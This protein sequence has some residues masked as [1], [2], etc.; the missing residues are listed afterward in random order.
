MFN[1]RIE[2]LQLY[3]VL[4]DA[5]NQSKRTVDKE[6]YDD[7]LWNALGS[8]LQTSTAGTRELVL[9]VDDI[10]ESSYREKALLYRL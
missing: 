1:K 4:A 6:S 7:L 3:Q 9:V 5:C 8:A 10:D 2:N